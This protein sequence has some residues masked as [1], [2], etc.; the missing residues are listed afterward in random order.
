MNTGKAVRLHIGIVLGDLTKIEI[1]KVIDP[2]VLQVETVA[3]IAT[4]TGVEKGVPHEV[5]AEVHREVDT[6][7]AAEVR[8]D[9]EK[10]LHTTE[11]RLAGR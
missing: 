1:V 7:I 10:D 9:E 8:P 11:D 4:G 2:Q 5:M 6:K 3:G